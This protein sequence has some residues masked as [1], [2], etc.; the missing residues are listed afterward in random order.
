MSFRISL[1]KREDEAGQSRSTTGNKI[2]RGKQGKGRKL[3]RIISGI[4]CVGE[5]RAKA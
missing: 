2:V 1:F 3:G 4:K 5:D